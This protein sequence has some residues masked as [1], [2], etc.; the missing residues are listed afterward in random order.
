MELTSEFAGDV[1]K[2]GRH[3]CKKKERVKG[4]GEGVEAKDE[5][6]PGASNRPRFLPAERRDLVLLQ[7][8]TT[9][10]FSSFSMS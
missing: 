8:T 4:E 2:T 9:L 10:T 3:G 7:T 1:E 5:S 6:S